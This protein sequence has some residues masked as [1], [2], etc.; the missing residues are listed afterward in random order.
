MKKKKIKIALAQIKIEQK[1]IEKNCKKIFERIE[2]AANKNVD[3]ICF[4]ELAN[5]G[6]TITSNELKNISEELEKNFIKQLQEKARLFKIHIL[7]GYLESKTTKKSRN[8]YNSCIFIDDKGKILANARKVYLWKKEKTKF[9][10]GNKFVVKNTKFGKIGILLCYDLEFPEPA[11]IECLKGAEII[12]VPS[13]WSFSAENRWH[14]DLAANSLFN[15]LF[16]AGCNAVGDSCCGKSKIVEPDGSTLIEASGTNEELLIASIDL[17]KLSEVRAKIPYLM[18]L[19]K[20]IFS[21]GK[22]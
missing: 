2:E 21:S 3:I 7:V 11:R 4:P 6:Y 8:F 16:I 20:D 10:A 1:N 12:F 22:Y 9:K 15:L 5:I 14:I 17:T 13:L 18:D 19:K